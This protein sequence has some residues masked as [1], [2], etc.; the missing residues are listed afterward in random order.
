MNFILHHSL[1][2]FYQRNWI[3][4]TLIFHWPPPI[5][6]LRDQ[7]LALRRIS[8]RTLVPPFSS[9]LVLVRKLSVSLEPPFHS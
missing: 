1:Y 8:N 5:S 4:K 2:V 7:R 3:F 9:A 6:F